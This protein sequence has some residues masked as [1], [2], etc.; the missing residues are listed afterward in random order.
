[1]V[2]EITNPENHHDQLCVK[3]SLIIYV[4]LFEFEKF[5]NELSLDVIFLIIF[6]KSVNDLFHVFI[7]I[8]KTLFDKS[9]ISPRQEVKN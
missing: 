6:Q 3:N 8:L 5:R 4:N 7:I 1:M 2:A 9:L